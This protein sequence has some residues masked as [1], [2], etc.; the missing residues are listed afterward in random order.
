MEIL[1]KGKKATKPIFGCLG[2]GCVFTANEDEFYYDSND[3][4]NYCC[5]PDCGTKCTGTEISCYFCEYVEKCEI[6]RSAYDEEICDS[7]K[8]S[9]CKL[10]TRLGY[11][12]YHIEEE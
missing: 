3:E 7:F 8:V 5:C 9:K 10:W 12:M 1:V 11:Q 4:T 6:R 2:C